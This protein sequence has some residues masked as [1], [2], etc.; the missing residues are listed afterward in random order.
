MKKKESFCYMEKNPN[1]QNNRLLTMTRKV[2]N[3]ILIIVLI[4]YG[5]LAHADWDQSN[6]RVLTIEVF[7]GKVLD[8][9]KNVGTIF[10]ADPQ[11]VD[12]HVKEPGILYLYSKKLG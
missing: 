6:T 9:G 12:F 2:W 7:Q 3:I 5:Y 11:I 1:N 8:I 4:G 10:I